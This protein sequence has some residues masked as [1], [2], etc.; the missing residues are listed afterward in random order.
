MGTFVLVPGAGGMAWY[1]H[2]VAPLIRAAGHEAIAV[3]LPGDD[4]NSGLAAYADIVIRAIAKR[5]DVILVAQSLAGFTAPL[6]CKRAPVRMAVLV[7]AMIPEPGETAGAWW[8]ATGAV[9]AREKAATRRGYATE[10]DV[11]TY[12]LHDVPQDVLRTGPEHPREEADAVFG[13]PCRFERWPD[14]P[15]HVLAA[16]DDRFFPV[17]FQRRVARERLGKELEE[18]PGGHLVALSNPK[19]LTDR[20]LAYERR[21]AR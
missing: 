5:S 17:E 8:G 3:D 18:I 4:R 19:G 21:L 12:F 6:V 1:W 7:N 11:A 15:I 14:I 9:E 16:K 13:E 2:R 20:L 10:F